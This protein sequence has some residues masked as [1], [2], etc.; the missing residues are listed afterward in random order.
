MWCCWGMSF[1]VPITQ[2]Q[3]LLMI[4]MHGIKAGVGTNGEFFARI[5][6]GKF[7]SDGNLFYWHGKTLENKMKA[8]ELCKII[9]W[10]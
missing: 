1:T 5:P 2:G 6:C 9:K 7:T 10:T 4:P 8:W 3:P